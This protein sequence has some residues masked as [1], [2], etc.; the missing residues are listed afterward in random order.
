[1]LEGDICVNCRWYESNP[2]RLRRGGPEYD[3]RCRVDP[4]VG[5]DADGRMVW[6]RVDIGDWCGRF[7]R[8]DPGQAEGMAPGQPAGPQV[9]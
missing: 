3:G 9:G 5:I 6:A 8:R 1:M 2:G 7:R 4:P